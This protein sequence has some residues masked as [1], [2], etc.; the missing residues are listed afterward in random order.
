MTKQGIELCSNQQW[1]SDSCFQSTRGLSWNSL[2]LTPLSFSLFFCCCLG[3]KC[4]NICNSFVFP[5]EFVL[6]VL[7][8]MPVQTIVLP[9]H[10]QLMR[11][12]C[13]SCMEAMNWGRSFFPAEDIN[14]WGS[15]SPMHPTKLPPWCTGK[16][17]K[18]QML[19]L[20][21]QDKIFTKETANFL[22]RI[23]SAA[24]N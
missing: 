9:A 14:G 10:L 22:G 18:I 11:T 2:S 5:I 6:H 19:G 20:L 1:N 4:I 16:S 21:L 24:K 12:G 8:C 7:Y 23:F 17:G 3:R 13:I 15:S